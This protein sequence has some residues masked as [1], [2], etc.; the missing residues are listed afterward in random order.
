MCLERHRSRTDKEQ[1]KCGIDVRSVVI[2]GFDSQITMKK[3][4]IKDK[5]AVQIQ[6]KAVSGLVT[7]LSSAEFLLKRRVSPDMNE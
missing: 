2:R 6:L 5:P 4:P 1:D 7:I 3:N